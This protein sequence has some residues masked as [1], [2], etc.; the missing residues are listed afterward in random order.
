MAIRCPLRSS[1]GFASP[2]LIVGIVAGVLALGLAI[3]TK[4]VESCKA[5]AA[6]FVA[7]VKANGE[8]AKA[9]AEAK[10]KEDAKRVTDAV[11]ERDTALKRLRQSNTTSRQLSRTASAPKGSS[12]ICIGTPAYNAAME[13]YR[14]RIQRGMDGTSGLATEGDA[15]QID[16]QALVKAWPLQMT[17]TLKP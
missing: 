15:A 12:E 6:A 8:A 11:S 3:Q 2:L 17:P 4:R 14:G 1:D 10:E 5:K 13:R 9:K 16:A 7:Q